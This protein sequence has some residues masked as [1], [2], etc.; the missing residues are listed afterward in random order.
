M[1]GLVLLKDGDS[2]TSTD[3][4]V[5]LGAG[6][7]D[8]W[9]L[10]RDEGSRTSTDAAFFYGASLGEHTY[11]GCQVNVPRIDETGC[12]SHSPKALF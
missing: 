5:I 10:I 12:T 1:D 4:V 9:I 8:G 6:V 7:F 2:R 3:D 11:V